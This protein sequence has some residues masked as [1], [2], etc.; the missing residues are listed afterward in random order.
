MM[1]PVVQVTRNGNLIL[2]PL[3]QVIA[4]NCTA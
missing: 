2:S 1:K 4:D 3:N